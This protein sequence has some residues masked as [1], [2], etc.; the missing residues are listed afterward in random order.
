MGQSLEFYAGD[1]AAIGAD[2]AALEFDELRDG[3]RARAYA[4]FSLHLAPDDLETLSAVLG[5]PSLIDSLGAEVGTFD[6]GGGSASLVSS[7]WVGAVAGADDRSAAG[8]AAAWFRQLGDGTAPAVTPEAVQA[9]S[10]LIRLCRLAVR[11][12]VQVVHAWSL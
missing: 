11:E 4:D 1:A 6:D 12:C 9:V 3:T 10:A 8:L 7:E 2:F 5:A